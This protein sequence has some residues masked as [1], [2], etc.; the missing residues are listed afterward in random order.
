MK[1]SELNLESELQYYIELYKPFSQ[2]GFLLFEQKRLW[3]DSPSTNNM[4]KIGKLL[5]R[6]ILECKGRKFSPKPILEFITVLNQKI[7]CRELQFSC[8]SLLDKNGEFQ[9]ITDELSKKVFGKVLFQLI[10]HT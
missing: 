3:A 7:N 6:G 8:K 5:E 9:S 1:S 2:R 10:I 4:Q